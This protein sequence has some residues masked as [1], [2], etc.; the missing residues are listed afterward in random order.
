MTVSA[1]APKMG[2]ATEGEWAEL[3]EWCRNRNRFRPSGFADPEL[4]GSI[5]CEESQNY[6][7]VDY[8]LVRALRAGVPLEKLL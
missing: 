5:V 4:I 2:P 1:P 3:K 8:V 6:A 7:V